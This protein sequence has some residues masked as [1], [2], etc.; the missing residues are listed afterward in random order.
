[1]TAQPARHAITAASRPRLGT[2]VRLHFDRLRGRW[3]LLAPEKVIWPD[4]VSVDILRR[5]DGTATVDAIVA[6]LTRD[7]NA[8]A[9]EIG[10]DVTDFLQ[11]WCDRLLVRCEVTA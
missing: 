7:Y 9:G 5:C 8:P 4:E 11:Q 6:A 3:A 1:M 10:P 2:G